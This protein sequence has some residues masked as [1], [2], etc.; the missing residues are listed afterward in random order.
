MPA[1]VA[2]MSA[3]SVSQA[4]LSGDI[5]TALLAVQTNRTQLLDRQ[6]SSQIEAVQQKNEQAA[7]LN[8]VMSAINTVMVPE[9]WRQRR[10]DQGLESRQ[11]GET[12][13]R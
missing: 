12:K 3:S 1:A 7:K 8:A 13:C 2:V 6:L 10:H 9:G 11:G 5:E 4:L